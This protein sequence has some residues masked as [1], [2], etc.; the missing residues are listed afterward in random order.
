MKK[1][2]NKKALKTYQKEVNKVKNERGIKYQDAVQIVK[3]SNLMS[4]IKLPKLPKPKPKQQTK[5]QLFDN[6]VTELDINNLVNSWD[7]I[8]NLDENL[9]VKIGDHQSKTFT[10]KKDE[11]EKFN[12]MI[13]NLKCEKKGL[14]N[15][16][17][18]CSPQTYGIG[19]KE[20]WQIDESKSNPGMFVS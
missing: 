19:I 5:Q 13:K 16:R 10:I 8:S 18:D 7:N 4:K 11:I 2:S 20:V 14:F 12:N 17:K 6:V 9:G 1:K 3:K 15:L